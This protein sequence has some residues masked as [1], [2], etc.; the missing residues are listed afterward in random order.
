MQ[1]SDEA[2]TTQE[3]KSWQGIHLLHF[4]GSSCSQKVRIFL[5]EKRIA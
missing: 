3:V 2:V 4:Q 1:L 5:A